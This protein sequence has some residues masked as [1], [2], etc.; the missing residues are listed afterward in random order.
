MG[1]DDQQIAGAFGQ[2]L[3]PFCRHEHIILQPNTSHALD[4]RAGLNREDH[5]RREGRDVTRVSP[6]DPGRFVHFESETMAGAVAERRS[7]TRFFQPA[8]GGAIHVG[9]SGARSGRRECGALGLAH[10]FEKRPRPGVDV[11]DRGHPGK[12]D[13]V[14]V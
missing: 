14:S 7:Q 13:A 11:A 3:T 4:V 1:S 8:A 12:V 6:A 5:A 10:R 2:H 9:A